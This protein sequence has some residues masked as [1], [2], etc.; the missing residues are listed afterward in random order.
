MIEPGDI[1]RHFKGSYYQVITL[2]SLESNL[3]PYVVYSSLETGQTFVRSLQ[4]FQSKVSK[5]HQYLKQVFEESSLLEINV[6]NLVGWPS[7]GFKLRLEANAEFS[8]SE[9]ASLSACGFDIAELLRLR[10]E[11]IVLRFLKICSKPED[12]EK[13]KTDLQIT[14]K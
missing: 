8:S 14:I 3:E 11:R 4:S 12:I 10:S 7:G 13:F 6:C 1:Y 2:A 5:L 9:F